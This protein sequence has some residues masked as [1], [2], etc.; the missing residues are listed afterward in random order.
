MDWAQLA[1]HSEAV[2]VRLNHRLGV[3][4]FLDAGVRGLMDN[5]AVQDVLLA[6]SWIKQNAIALQVDP[7]SMV[8]LGLGSGAYLLCLLM[9]SSAKAVF[10]RALLQGPCTTT[11]LP[12]NSPQTGR[13][14]LERMS[15]HLNCSSRRIAGQA[16]CLREASAEDVLRISRELE[17]PLRF[18]PSPFNGDVL[19]TLHE[20][21]HFDGVK[22][23]LGSDVT[24][25]KRLY[26]DVIFAFLTASGNASVPGLAN[27]FLA[28]MSLMKGDTSE[29]E[30]AAFERAFKNTTRSEF[31]ECLVHMWTTCSSKMLADEVTEKGGSLF[32]YVV[33][34]TLPYDMPL[35]L[36]EISGFLIRGQ[37]PAFVVFS[38]SAQ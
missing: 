35:T 2:V 1:A 5:V 17:G 4:G 12:R 7:G 18:V 37:V 26:D 34:S 8:A 11:P 6:L 28:V 13:V 14:Y 36:Q 10:T 15:R 29:F 27:I 19:S 21:A 22:L 25:G 9:M 31:E 38:C 23:L 16:K 20:T 24:E 33:N 30:A 3:F 32:H